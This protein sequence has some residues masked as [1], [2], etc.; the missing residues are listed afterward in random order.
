MTN[1]ILEMEKKFFK[2]DYM[3]NREWLEQTI[4]DDFIECGKSGRLFDKNETIRSLLS[5]KADREIKISQFDCNKI[6]HQ[7]WIVHYVTYADSEKAFYRTSIWVGE[8]LQRLYFH[9]ATELDIAAASKKY[10]G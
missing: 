4:H 3:S 5:C 2:Y 6:D 8:K 1:M 10:L 9:Q 7:S